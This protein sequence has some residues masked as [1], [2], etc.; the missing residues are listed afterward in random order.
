M[1]QTV[2][3]W[4]KITIARWEEKITQLRIG[5]S[6]TLINSFAHQVITDSAG[7]PDLI[8]FTF[9]YY[10]RMVDMGVGRGM[11][12]GNRSTSQFWDAREDNGRLIKKNRK[13]K[14]WYS[15]PFGREVHKLGEL[16]AQAYGQRAVA[17]IVNQ[18]EQK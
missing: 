4:A 11:P 17:I 18:I 3:D 14:P 5:D 7:N 13:P 6:N 1:N 10:G 8:R 16:L 9:E 12:I 2:I 15:K